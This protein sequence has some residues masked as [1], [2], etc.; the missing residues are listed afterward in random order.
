MLSSIL[1]HLSKY[2]DYTFDDVRN[3]KTHVDEYLS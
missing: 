1:N 3:A 2:M